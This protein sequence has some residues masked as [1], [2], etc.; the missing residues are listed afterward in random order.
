[1]I[2]G[3]CIRHTEFLIADACKISHLKIEEDKAEL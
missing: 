3:L 1:M 2:Q